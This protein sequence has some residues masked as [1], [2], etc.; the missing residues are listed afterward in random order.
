MYLK[1]NLIFGR[2]LRSILISIFIYFSSTGSCYS[3]NIINEKYVSLTGFKINE[4][5][6]IDMDTSEI[7]IKKDNIF[8]KFYNYLLNSNK[9]PEIPKKFDFSIVGAPHYASDIEFAVVVVASALYSVKNNKNYSPKSTI[10]LSGDFSTNGYIYTGL[11]GVVRLK[12][13]KMRINHD[14]YFYSQTSDFWGIGYE[15]GRY[16]PKS[17]FKRVNGVA[18]VDFMYNFYDRFY[19][20]PSLKF[21]YLNALYFSNISYINGEPKYNFNLGLGASIVYDSRDFAPNAQSGQFMSFEQLV[22]PSVFSNSGLFQRS[23]FFYRYY[24]KITEGTVIASEFHLVSVYGDTPWT[25]L[26]YMGGSFRMRG[27]YEGRYRDRNIAEVQVELR[28]KI[29]KRNGIVLWLGAGNV[30]WD[31][32]KFKMSHTLPCFGVGYR[33]EFKNRINLRM[34]IGRGIGQTNVVFSIEEAF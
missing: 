14:F 24:Y 7:K 2:L 31:Y 3:E 28:Q 27:Y 34:D 30:F 19:I 16:A 1:K 23:E 11:N 6:N 9:E 32:S 33:W 22:S 21:S 10:S 29:F 13:D 17:K 4:I 25:V 18:K 20:G 26:P 5:H 12:D 15:M 8:K